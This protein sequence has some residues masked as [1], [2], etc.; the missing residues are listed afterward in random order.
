MILQEEIE[1]KVKEIF[2]DKLS[3]DEAKVTPEANLINDLGADSL[4]TVEFIMEIEKAFDVLIPDEV[5]I[6]METISDIIQYI[7]TTLQQKS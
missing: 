4:D 6:K 7:K 1:Q 2:V 5:A 3:V